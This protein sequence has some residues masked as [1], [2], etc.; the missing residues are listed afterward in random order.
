MTRSTKFDSL[1]LCNLD[2]MFL[3]CSRW[4]ST[5]EEKMP[6]MFYG[7]DISMFAD[8]QC[9]NTTHYK[10]LSSTHTAHY[11]AHHYTQRRRWVNSPAEY[12]GTRLARHSHIVQRAP[13][14]RPN[15]PN[16]NNR[17]R[18]TAVIHGKIALDNVVSA[19]PWGT[20]SRSAAGGGGGGVPEY[21][22]RA[23]GTGWLVR[24]VCTVAD[25][26]RRV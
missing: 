26:P 16:N 7:D 3:C 23:P 11:K 19:G 20:R 4:Y 13:R 12:P 5:Y 25:P 17:L 8:C 24:R 10:T 15:P 14:S 1:Q 6:L 21:T 9:L 22:Y 2:I 18:S